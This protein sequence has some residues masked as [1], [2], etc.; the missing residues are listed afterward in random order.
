[1]VGGPQTEDVAPLLGT[2]V[3]LVRPAGTSGV[4]AAQH[5]LGRIWQRRA[6]AE[7]WFQEI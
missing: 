2:H 6:C 7:G 5:I 4:D 3:P 1:M